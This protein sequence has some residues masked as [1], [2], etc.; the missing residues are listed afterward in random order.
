VAAPV[1]A[2]ERTG[3]FGAFSRSERLTR[4]HRW[5]VFALIAMAFILSLLISGAFIPVGAGLAA[6]TRPFAIAPAVASGL[7]QALSA[8]VTC[9]GAAALYLELRQAREGV[10]AEDLAAVFA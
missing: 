10:S 2:V 6:V 8:M 5:A 9:A 4:G 7:A 1:A 3:V